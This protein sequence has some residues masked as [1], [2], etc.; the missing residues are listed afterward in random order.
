MKISDDFYDEAGNST[1]AT[2]FGILCAIASAL[3]TVSYSGAAY[4]FIGILVG[5]LLAFKIDGSHHIITLILYIL[6]C[7]AMGLPICVTLGKGP[8]LLGHAHLIRQV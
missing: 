5:T 8:L 4:I 6:I 2:I 3:A 1:M 7:L